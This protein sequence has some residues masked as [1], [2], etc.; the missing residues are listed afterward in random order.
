MENERNQCRRCGGN[1]IPSKALMNYHYIDKSYHRGEK[2]FETKLLDCLKCS[3]CGH[4]WIPIKSTTEI[5]LEWWE[6]EIEKVGLSY[7]YGFD[8]NTNR[9]LEE[10]EEIWRKETQEGSDREIIE[11]VLSNLKSKEKKSNSELALEWW[12][13]LSEDRRLDET[14]RVRINGPISLYSVKLTGKEIEEIWLKE[15]NRIEDEVFKPNQKQFKQFNPE[16]FK[17]YI[18]KFSDEDKMKAFKILNEEFAYYSHE[19]MKIVQKSHDE[20]IKI[21]QNKILKLSK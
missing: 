9:T 7:K 2:E 18:D 17:A 8:G 14:N 4:S 15:C 21:L 16:L 3:S 6:S 11:Y 20:Q 19:Q 10:I 13:N 12:N 1:A 5:A